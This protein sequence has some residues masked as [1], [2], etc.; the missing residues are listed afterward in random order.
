MSHLMTFLIFFYLDQFYP[1]FKYIKE[2][3]RF[4]KANPEQI[5]NLHYEDIKEVNY[6]TYKLNLT[7][8]LSVY[9]TNPNN[10]QLTLLAFLLHVYIMLYFESTK[11]FVSS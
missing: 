10:S 5:L 6:N 9:T 11:L 2:W 3:E 7:F 4:S 8:A 1:W